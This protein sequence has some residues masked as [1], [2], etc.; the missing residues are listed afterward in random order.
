M[1][2]VPRPSADEAGETASSSLLSSSEGV[3][4]LRTSRLYES[5]LVASAFDEA[6]IPYFRV[7]QAF[8]GEIF[9]MP[10]T[11]SM[12]SGAMWL[13]VVPQRVAVEAKALVTDLPVSEDT[14]PGMRDFQPDPKAQR[15][16][17]SYA[18]LALLLFALVLLWPFVQILVQ[19]CRQ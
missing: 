5:D 10:A 2:D 7:E 12:G 16:W 9:A 4:V 19:F 17:K 1:P 18:F 11:P 15:F 6:G 13:V 3:V 14:S 8:D